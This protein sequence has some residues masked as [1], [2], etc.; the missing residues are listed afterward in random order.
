MALQYPR[1]DDKMNRKVET[2]QH[3][4]NAAW[5][6]LFFGLSVI[7]MESTTAMGGG[8]T[9]RWLLDLCHT[10]W[11][12]KDGVRFE[13]AHLVLRKV[14]HFTGYGILA[15]LFRR[16][17]HSTV[18]R[19]SSMSR[20]RMRKV[21]MALAVFSTF[22]VACM[23][24]WHQSTLPGRVSSFHDVMIDTTGALLFNFSLYFVAAHRR[25]A[26]IPQAAPAFGQKLSPFSAPL[27]R[28]G[29]A[30]R[31]RSARTNALHRNLLR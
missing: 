26:L 21:A 29:A 12:Q 25:R 19:A 3:P 2:Q 18:R 10:L 11:G 15:L 23:D 17:W 4:G 7:C 5:I 30:W 16:G 13:E 27:R 22:F 1:T 24:E 8:N 9:S 31:S 20:I 14:G 6:P 28:T